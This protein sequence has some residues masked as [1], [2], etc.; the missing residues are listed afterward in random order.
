MSASPPRLLSGP[1]LRALSGRSDARGAARIS[2]HVA[3]MASAGW[4]VA[5][6]PGWTILPAMLLL[7]VVQVSLFA[8]LHE[9]MHLTAFA[10]RR[11]NSVVGWLVGC[12]SLLNWH[13]Y[14][15][16]HLAH[17]RFTQDPVRDPEL[18]PPPPA[19]LAS[20]LARI[21]A[22][23]YWRARLKLI[24]DAWRGD[25]SA[26]P[27][28]APHAR[29]RIASSTRWMTVFV[30][31]LASGSAVL[32]GWWVPLAFWIGP[33]L[34]AQPL[35]R[36]YLLTEH[37]GCSED[38][39]G[40]ANTRTTLTNPLVRLL[41]WNMGFHAEHHLYPSIPFHRLA[42]AHAVLRDRLGVIEHGYARW[43][44][45]YLRSLLRPA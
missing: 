18:T 6:A 28:I 34:L 37:T 36:L 7:G 5:V 2:L 35:L 23:N 29:A 27:F 26:Y 40:L 19:G 38:A 41:M 24:A 45:R 14:G 42:D 31:A 16:F 39:D 32:L 10:S 44:W 1:D 11:T 8:P 25:L 21:A 15:A 4:L 22:L 20:Y 9:T 30:A 12:P 13:F 3:L 33:Q 43:H 17:H